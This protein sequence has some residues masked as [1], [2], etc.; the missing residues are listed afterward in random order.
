MAKVICKGHFD[1][2]IGI[3][4]A[5]YH[6]INMQGS[7]EDTCLESPTPLCVFTKQHLFYDA[8]M[9]IN[10]SLHVSVPVVKRFRPIIFCPAKT[11]PKN[12]G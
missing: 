9:M 4:H 10:G 5:P 2:E 7:L 6:V 1:S 12:G 8:T 3:A 11:G